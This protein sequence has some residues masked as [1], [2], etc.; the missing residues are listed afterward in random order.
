MYNCSKRTLMMSLAG[1]SIILGVTACDIPI[2]IQA[3][4]K[5]IEIN[6]NITIDQNVR[7][8]ID[9]DVEGLIEDNP[10]IF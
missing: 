5:P 1:L 2:K 3:P 10:D 7:V 8:Q 4:D 6:L 9:D